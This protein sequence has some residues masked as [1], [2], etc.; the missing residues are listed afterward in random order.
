VTTWVAEGE[1]MLLTVLRLVP[2][3]LKQQNTLV[4]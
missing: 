2:K 1:L 3:L 4:F